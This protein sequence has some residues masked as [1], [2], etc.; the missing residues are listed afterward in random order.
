MAVSSSRRSGLPIR[1]GDGLLF[2][3]IIRGYLP[4]IVRQLVAKAE[5]ESRA[6][7]G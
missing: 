6:A 2:G 5:T 3:R 4:T 7:Q 1:C